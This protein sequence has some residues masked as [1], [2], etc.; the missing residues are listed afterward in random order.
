MSDSAAPTVGQQQQLVLLDRVRVL[1]LRTR[2]YGEMA[3]EE[4]CEGFGMKPSELALRMVCTRIAC[5]GGQV[6]RI[7]KQND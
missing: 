6:E 5:S 3:G 2:E 4:L 7:S 1:N